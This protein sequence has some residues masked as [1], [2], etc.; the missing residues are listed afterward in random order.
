MSYSATDV[1]SE[2]K[3]GR[4]CVDKGLYLQVSPTGTKSWILRYK[5]NGRARHM[6]LGDY[7]TVTVSDARTRAAKARL[8]IVDGVDPLAEKRARIEAVRAV[9]SKTKTFAECAVV[10]IEKKAATLKNPKHL[11]QWTSTL[12][13]YAY[14]T[15]ENKPVGTITKADVA[16]VLEPIWRTKNETADR[17]RGRM[18]AVFDYAK[19]MGYREGDNPAAWKGNL[20]PILGDYQREARHQPSLPHARIGAFM[21]E[22]RKREGMAARALEFAILTAA[23]SGEALGATWAEIDLDAK[24]GSSRQAG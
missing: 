17:V 15:L 12:K 19:A 16:A 20:Q 2:T 4:Y 3:P 22:L 6:G 23:R 24:L 7:P 18:E 13:T 8:S 10:V 9:Q 11:A 5:L 21:A 1:K 14:P